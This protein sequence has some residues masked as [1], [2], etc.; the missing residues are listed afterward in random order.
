V[1]SDTSK[2][3]FGNNIFA[4]SIAAT[5]ISTLFGTIPVSLKIQS[6]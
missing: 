6:A 1:I 3:S 5:D 4:F 2:S